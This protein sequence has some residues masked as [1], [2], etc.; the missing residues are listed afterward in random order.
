MLTVMFRMRSI[1]IPVYYSTSPSLH[2]KIYIVAKDVFGKDRRLLT[3]IYEIDTVK[4]MIEAQPKTEQLKK[5]M[6]LDE[7]ISMYKIDRDELICHV[8]DQIT[9]SKYRNQVLLY[10]VYKEVLYK[11]AITRVIN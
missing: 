10:L 2:Q 9:Y 7:L 8:A 6:E 5:Y 1:E 3:S 4:E 11:E